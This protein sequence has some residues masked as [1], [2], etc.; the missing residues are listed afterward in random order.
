MSELTAVRELFD[1]A[2]SVPAAERQVFLSQACS[3]DLDLRRTVERLLRAESQW[4]LFDTKSS[5]ASGLDDEPTADVPRLEAGMRLGPY[6]IASSIDRGGMGEVYQAVDRRLDRQVAVKVLRRDTSN[7][8][9]ARGRFTR[10]A[11]TI[12]ALS[13]PNICQLFDVGH[14]D[15]TDYLVME[16]LPGETLAARLLRGRLPAA[17]AIPLALQIVDGLA[18]A[19]R[20]GIIHRDLK[21]ANIMVTPT[22]ARLLDFGLARSRLPRLPVGGLQAESGTFPEVGPLVGTLPYMAPEQLEGAD[23]DEQTDVF[24][25]G[26]V[27]FEMLTG[28]RAFDGEAATTVIA[29]VLNASCTAAGIGRSQG[30]GLARPDPGPLRGALS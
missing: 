6:Q 11:H 7:D 29:Q 24:A 15:G 9:R 25:F 10:E 8:A 3:D 22:G 30:T 26:V 19:H 17:E 13:H 12:A 21:P 5:A 14:A 1:R 28:R 20:A 23:A 27:L 4:S 18:A 16:F 2:L